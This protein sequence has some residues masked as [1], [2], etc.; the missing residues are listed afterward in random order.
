MRAP[1]ILLCTG[2]TAVLLVQSGC[3][4]LGSRQ[5]RAPVDTPPAEEIMDDIIYQDR[6]RPRGTIWDIFR[7]RPDQG[8]VGAVNKYIWNAALETLDFLPVQSVDPFTGVITTG[9]GTPPGGG[10]AY[11]ATIYVSDPALDARSL[12]VALMTR[13]G[14]APAATVRAVEDAILTRARQ[15]RQQDSRL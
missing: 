7:A 2:L 12:N 15:L 1:R 8:Q 5:N 4:V 6:R 11:R 3:G 14:P 10:R 13:G 9:F